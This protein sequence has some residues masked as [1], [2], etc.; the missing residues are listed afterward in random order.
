[1]AKECVQPLTYTVTQMA[2]AAQVSRPT[3]Y[4][5]M[6]MEGFPVVRIGRSPRIPV[7]AFERWLEKQA[8]VK[9]KGGRLI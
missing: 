9:R 4:K 2:Q 5:W 8:G 7:K 6:R 1:M 3:A